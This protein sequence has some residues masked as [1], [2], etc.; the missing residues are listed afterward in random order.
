M[1]GE[2]L[3]TAILRARLGNRGVHAVGVDEESDD[4]SR[5]QLGS[6][7]MQHQGGDIL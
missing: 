4:V 1:R 5:Q 2:N 3:D 7:S 6:A